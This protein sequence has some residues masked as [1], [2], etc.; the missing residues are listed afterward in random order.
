MRKVTKKRAN[1]KTVVKIF[2]GVVFVSIIALLRVHL[3][4]LIDGLKYEIG[5]EMGKEKLLLKD[6]ENLERELY[7][8]KSP[9]VIEE[10]AFDMGMNYPKDWQIKEV[11]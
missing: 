9:S 3:Y 5:E 8:L 11:R 10:K 4:V 1:F 2:L 6:K 7:S